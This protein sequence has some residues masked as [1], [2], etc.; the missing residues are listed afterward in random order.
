MTSMKNS[1]GALMLRFLFFLPPTQNKI[2]Y[3]LWFVPS[4]IPQRINK[5]IER[6]IYARSY[7]IPEIGFA[8]LNK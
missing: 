3:G 4:N 8:I 1:I 2:N 6:R 7:V 5:L